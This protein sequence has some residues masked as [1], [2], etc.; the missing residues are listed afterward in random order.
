MCI[1]DRVRKYVSEDHQERTR[2]QN[3]NQAV[4]ALDAK[5]GSRAATNQAVEAKA[6]ELGVSVNFLKDMAQRT[7]KG[8]LELMDASSKPRS[9][10]GRIPQDT[11]SASVTLSTQAGKPQPGTY[12]WYQDLRKTDPRQ[13]KRVYKQQMKDMV[14]NP[15]KF[16]ER[17]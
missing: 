14:D 7:P 1:R 5:F 4:T 6:A 17:A 13:Y 8:L 3:M 15:D 12:R 2:E 16:Y 9:T 11:N 10:A